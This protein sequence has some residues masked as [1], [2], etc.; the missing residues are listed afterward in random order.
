MANSK[1]KWLI[2]LPAPD[3]F[4]HQMAYFEKKINV[5]QQFQKNVL[6]LLS[7]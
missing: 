2:Y 6:L 5:K 7:M 1:S 3:G 4:G